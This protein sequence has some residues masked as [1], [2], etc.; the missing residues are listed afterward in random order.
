MFFSQIIH[1]TSGWE[2]PV[3]IWWHMSKDLKVTLLPN[4]CFGLLS[5]FRCPNSTWTEMHL[6]VSL[7]GTVWSSNTRLNTFK[8][9][10]ASILNRMCFVFFV[11]TRWIKMKNSV[12]FLSIPRGP[13]TS[14]CHRFMIQIK[15]KRS[16]ALAHRLSK[17][18]VDLISMYLCAHTSEIRKQR[19]TVYQSWAQNSR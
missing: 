5:W 4:Q 19:L 7:S 16:A 18:V 10:C 15:H 11:I 3:D 6:N 2:A 1:Y 17:V 9:Y 12:S 14:P 13:E 8:I